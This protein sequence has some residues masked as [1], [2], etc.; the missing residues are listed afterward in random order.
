MNLKQQII[1]SN[2]LSFS[3]WFWIAII[4]LI[5]IL[6]LINKT[7]KIQSFK[8][9]SNE[10]LDYDSIM[11]GIID[12]IN[13]SKP[14]YKELIKVCHPDRFVNESK[15]KNAEIIFQEITENENNYSRLKE[16]K[17][18]AEKELEIKFKQ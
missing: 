3:F 12:D 11:G 10:S 17:N 14:L 7:K 18:R 6:Y 4:E 16:L 5:I 8:V 9:N 15:Q 1:Q 2:N 13:L